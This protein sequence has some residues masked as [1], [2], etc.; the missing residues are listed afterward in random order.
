V[1]SYSVAQ[2]QGEFGIRMALGAQARDVLRLVLGK[3]AQ[4][5]LS[6]VAIGLIGSYAVTQILAAAIPSVPT[7]DPIAIALVTITLAAVAIAAC[8]LPARR[9]VALDPSAALRHE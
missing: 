3:G 2:R 5:V 8:W 4:L 1:T 9:T 7:S 6:G